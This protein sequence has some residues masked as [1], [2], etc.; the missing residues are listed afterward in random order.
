MALK[1]NKGSG[2][3]A[4]TPTPAPVAAAPQDSAPYTPPP[5]G[6][7]FKRGNQ[8]AD[9]LKHEEKRIEQKY[10]GMW[11]FWLDDPAGEKPKNRE[12]RSTARVTFVDGFVTDQGILDCFMYREHRVFLH[13]EWTT[14][15]CVGEQEPCPICETGDDPSLVGVFTIIDHTEVK[16]K[17]A[18]YKDRAMLFVAKRHTLRQLQALAT[19]RK[20]IS[21]WTVQISRVG[22]KSA[23][24]GDTFDFLEHH[25]EAYL[26]KTYVKTDEKTKKTETVYKVADYQKEIRYL[27]A[28]ELRKLGFGK[29]SPV[30]SESGPKDDSAPAGVKV[31]S[32]L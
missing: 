4:V 9:A 15:V 22:E 1:L 26:R 8:V 27:S 12:L 3:K 30:G 18:V 5:S 28:P 6:T 11:R 17:K 10:S 25:N 2:V 19:P 23:A 13:G 31:A 29:G 16:G 21:G 24:V 32:Q 7:W 20:G 14:L